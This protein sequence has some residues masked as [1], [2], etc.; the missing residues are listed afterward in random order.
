MTDPTPPPLPQPAHH[1]LAGM[2]AR[3]AGDQAALAHRVT[4]IED[5]VEDLAGV[6]DDIEAVLDHHA[7]PAP[8]VP[9]AAASQSSPTSPTSPD[10]D[11]TAAD[12][13]L[14]MRRL[15]AWVGDNIATLLERK[16]PQTNGWPYWCRRWW[17][18][19]EAIA[20]FEALRR[21]WTE[22]VISDGNA[23]VV[24]FEH[25]DAM[26]GVLCGENG[27]FCGCLKGQHRDDTSARPLGQDDPDES[28]FTELEHAHDPPPTW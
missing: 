4:A 20:R 25:L 9:P 22:A 3:L 27:P 21:S 18:H 2:L 8:P 7:S 26:L 13:A 15:V 23:M 12:D 19:P 1:E 6:F 16:I 10:D 14:D 11:I 5:K 28:Y 17:L 24:Y